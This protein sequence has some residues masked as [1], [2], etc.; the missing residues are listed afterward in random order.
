MKKYVFFII[1][2]VAVSPHI[3]AQEAKSVVQLM[4]FS[5]QG[6][7]SDEA[8][9]LEALIQS[10]IVDLGDSTNYETVTEI[11][12][13]QTEIS[14]PDYIITGSISRVADERVLKLELVNTQTGD[15]M[16]FT[17]NH[18]TTSDL[19][20]KSRSLVEEALTSGNETDSPPETSEAISED[21]IA[22]TWKGDR[23]I[24][25]IRLQ[26]N[27]S[28]M[29]IFSSGARM[30]L[31]YAINNN[32]ITITQNSP[33]TE[34]FY[35]PVPRNIASE[36]VQV[37]EP[38]T[39]EMRLYN[40]GTDLKGTKKATAVEYTEDSVKNFLFGTVRNAEWTKIN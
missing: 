6:L 5:I 24:E 10:Y 22:G 26:R 2:L 18:K 30:T 15:V 21:V 25:M 9:L 38:M 17:S 36:L 34:R 14:N 3:K 11:P 20:L 28:G 13:S 29:A 39:W 12:D 27:G 16:Q 1:C 19:A 4:P 33:N 32:V 31:S 23:G 7:G 8:K 40:H 37:A 35:H